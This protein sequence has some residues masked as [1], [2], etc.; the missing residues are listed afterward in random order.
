ML[1]RELAPISEEVWKEIDERAKEVLMAYLSA[2]KV[3]NVNGPKGLDFSAITE[4]RLSNLEQKD[5]ICYGN[6]QVLPL[7]EARIE[8]EME[9]WELDNLNR[10]AK[11]IDYTPLEKAAKEMALFEENVIYNGLEEAII[12]GL[13][14]SVDEELELREEP[15]GL[16]EDITNGVIKLRE[17]F[18][19]GNLNLV[20]G[21]EAYKKIISGASGY[22]LKK[23]IEDLIEGDIVYS[24]VVDGAYLIPYNHDDL[25]L[26]I[27]RDFS[28]GYQAHT[29]ERIKFFI[30]ESFTFR[31]LDPEI[32]VK[33]K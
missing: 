7:T 18:V 2:R 32:I 6:Y 3:V 22:P 4:G 28:I 9:R 19:E 11:D 24:H 23:R 10:G 14:D 30:A 13:K 31:V 15:K 26:T 8:F 1:Y 27:G 17:A 12:E 21:K 5:N 33:F 20:V 16:M 29:N 25:E